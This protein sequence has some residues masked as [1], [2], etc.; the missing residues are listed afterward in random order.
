ML[1]LFNCHRI[2]VSFFEIMSFIF[3][4]SFQGC[5]KVTSKTLQTV[6]KYFPKLRYLCISW[7]LYMS[8]KSNLLDTLPLL[9]LAFDFDEDYSDF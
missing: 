6:K 1:I 7:G 3:S 8:H 4:P 5:P 9:K 2:V